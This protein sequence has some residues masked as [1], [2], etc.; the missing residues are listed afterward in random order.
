MSEIINETINE[1]NKPT[2]S[3]VFSIEDDPVTVLEKIN[4][5]ERYLKEIDTRV[6]TSINTAN[7]ALEKAN[8]AFEANGTLVKINGENQLTWSADFAESERQKSKN[9][10]G[11]I[12]FEQTV[13]GVTIKLVSSSQTIILNG[14]ATSTFDAMAT[15]RNMLPYVSNMQGEDLKVTAYYLSGTKSDTAI[16]FIS[17]VDNDNVFGDRS[18]GIALPDNNLTSIN[19]S[20]SKNSTYNTLMLY[21]VNG[22][23]FTNYMFRIQIE[24]GQ[25]TDWEYPYGAI[26]HKSEIEPVLIYDK[27]TKNTIG[28]T[29]YTDGIP[30]NNT[31]IGADFSSYKKVEIIGV[32]RLIPIISTIDLTLP[33]NDAYYYGSGGMSFNSPTGDA[34]QYYLFMTC[35][36]SLDKS[37]LIL[38]KSGYNDVVETDHKVIRIVGYK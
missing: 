13:N 34:N 20:P 9:L 2:Q 5:V 30:I 38:L 7:E 35:A 16:A 25:V 8:N 31:Y 37:Q 6:D 32:N 22:T 15:V 11:L 17:T 29:A 1:L 12:D 27:D 28:G 24:K 21:T 4:Q 10:C 26:G 18:V 23:S 19:F 36:V 3:N 33:T 14:T